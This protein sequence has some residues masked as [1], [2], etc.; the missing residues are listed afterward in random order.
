MKEVLTAGLLLAA[1]GYDVTRRKIRNGLLG[2]GAIAGLLVTLYEC[3]VVQMGECIIRCIV[4][5]AICWPLFL[6]RAIGAGDIKLLGIIG[7]MH[8]TS[9][10]LNVVLVFLTLSG[11]G[12]F[13]LLC[14]NGLF[15]K[16]MRYAFSYFTTGRMDKRL[17]Y[18]KRI[19]GTEMTMILTPY[20]LAA[21]LLAMAGRWCGLW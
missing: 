6:L 3:G 12:A 21:Y 1:T 14:K 4:I 13:C 11:I 7:G 16:R 10:F 17:Y 8:S 18:D 19:D 9:F 5:V 20:L 15:S 2:I